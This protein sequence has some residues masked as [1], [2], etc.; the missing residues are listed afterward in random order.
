MGRE[1]L[2]R[3]ESDYTPEQNL[4][5]LMAVYREAIAERAA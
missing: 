4:G 1:A 5:A 3:Y 2:H